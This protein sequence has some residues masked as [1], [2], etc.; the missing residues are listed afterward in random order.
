MFISVRHYFY[1]VAGC[2]VRGVDLIAGAH[3]IETRNPF[4]ARPVM[5]F[6]LNLPFDLRVSV[7]PK[8]MINRLF[9][10]R[11]RPDQVLPKKGFTGHCNDSLPW[12]GIDLD[13][14]GNRDLDWREIV[15]KSFYKD[16]S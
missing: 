1:Q 9:L 2:D 3:G 7:T 12:L 11:W 6:A 14:T 16:P 5:Q 15:L 8:P 4:L 10:D 13:S